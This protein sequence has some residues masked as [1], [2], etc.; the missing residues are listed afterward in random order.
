M[1]ILF[2]LSKNSMGASQNDE[3]QRKRKNLGI[4]DFLVLFDKKFGF[5]V[6]K[7]LPFSTILLGELKYLKK[8][9]NQF[10]NRRFS[11]ILFFE[12]ENPD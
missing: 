7:N 10:G 8:I 1:I 9:Q 2:L 5:R 11:M 4:E 6:S 3:F 12:S